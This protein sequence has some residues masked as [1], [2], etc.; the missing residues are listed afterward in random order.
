M[1]WSSRACGNVCRP[2]SK[3]EVTIR[4]K[5]DYRLKTFPFRNGRGPE[6]NGCIEELPDKRGLRVA[7]IALSLQCTEVDTPIIELIIVNHLEDAVAAL[8]ANLSD[9]ETDYL[10]ELYKPNRV[11][12]IENRFRD[13]KTKRG[14][15]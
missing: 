8:K 10:E 2:H 14:V 13:R 3:V 5:C 7:Q 6:I 12:G 11:T 1:P 4:G 15:L 9:S